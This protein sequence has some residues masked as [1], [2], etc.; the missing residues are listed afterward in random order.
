MEWAVGG[1]AGSSTERF[2]REKVDLGR[3]PLLG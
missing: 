2:V 3:S 1:I